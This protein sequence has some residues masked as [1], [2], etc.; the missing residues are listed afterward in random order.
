MFTVD[1]MNTLPIKGALFKCGDD[2]TSLN[3]SSP[4]YQIV[5]I[6]S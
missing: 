1:W 6:Y 4:R 2:Q 3:A 5:Y